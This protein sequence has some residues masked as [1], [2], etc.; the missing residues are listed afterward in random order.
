[1]AEIG[2]AGVEGSG[3]SATSTIKDDV[4][5]VVAYCPINNLVNA[6]RGCEWQYN[7][8]RNDSNTGALNGVSYSAG[9]QVAASKE[10]AEQFPAY[11]QDL[12]LKLADGQQ[13]TAD[14]MPD[15][16]KAQVKAEIERQLAKGTTVPHLGENFVTSRATLPNDWLEHDGSKVI[17][18]DYQK[19]LDYVAANQALKTVVAFD[20]VAVNG[21]TAI[22]GETNLFGNSQY[23]YSNFTQ[24]SWDHNSKTAD[25][26]GADDTGLTWEDYLNSNSSTANLLNA[27]IKMVN[28]I[29]YLNTTTDTAPNW[30]IRHGMVDRDTSFAMQ[31]I[32]YYAVSNDPKVKDVNFKLPYLTGHSGNYDV[33]EAFTWI[34]EKLDSAQ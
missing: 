33:Q 18:I 10:I 25:G 24:W 7:A 1:M 16:I 4:F 6:D 27:Q 20:A 30:Y 15:Q 23:E 11:L 26:S 29:A 3:T 22:S 9:P 32:L 14:N 34:R 21:N 2:A 17:S 28:P 31:M 13:L 19:F 12:N 8:S 5:A